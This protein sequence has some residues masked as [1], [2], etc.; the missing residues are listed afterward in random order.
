MKPDKE[1]PDDISRNP[2]E[3]EY[4]NTFSYNPED[5][6]TRADEK[7]D[8]LL[9]NRGSIDPEDL[10]RQGK[11]RAA[12]LASEESAASER[13][14]LEDQVGSLYSGMDKEESGSKKG[15]RQRFNMKSL[16][17]NRLKITLGGGITGLVIAGIIAGFGLLGNFK[18]EHLFQ[19]LD[20]TSYARFN[21]AF[22]RRSDKWFQTYIKMR[23]SEFNGEI[24]N[25][26]EPI[27]FRARSVDTNNP[28]RDWYKTL[29][30]GGFEAELAKKGIVFTS[31]FDSSSGSPVKFTRLALNVEGRNGPVSTSID[32]S[33]L[34]GRDLRNGNLDALIREYDQIIDRKLTQT[35]DTDRDARLAIKKTVDTELN[36]LSWYKR[37]TLRKNIQNMTGVRSW[38]F[39]ETT[40]E[41]LANKRQSV[42]SKF[43]RMA[44]PESTKSGKFI[45]CLMGVGSCN[46]SADPGNPENQATDA[47][48]D[49]PAARDE[50]SRNQF[51]ENGNL[52]VDE[53]GNPLPGGTDGTGAGWVETATDEATDAIENEA[54]DVAG[55]GFK[56]AFI[57]QLLSKFNAATGLVSIADNIRTIHNNIIGGKL[58][59]AI[60]SAKTAQVI[61]VYATYHTISDQ[62]K[63]G[64]LERSGLL[65]TK[66]NP[67]EFNAVME[68]LN[69]F[70]QSEMYNAYFPKKESNAFIGSAFAQSGDSRVG[71]GESGLSRSE[72][73]KETHTP[74]KQDIHYLCAENTVGGKSNAA[75]FT[76][77]YK[78]SVG[79][80]I[81]PFVNAYAGVRDAPGFKQVADLGLGVGNALGNIL[82]PVI[83]GVL[84]GIGLDKGIESALG[85]IMSKVLS[86]AG[87]GPMT[88]FSEPGGYQFNLVAQGS[89]AAAA[90]SA[91]QTGAALSTQLSR[92]YL[93][94]LAAE[95]HQDKLATMSIKNRLFSLSDP[96]SITHRSL[97]ALDSTQSN[98]TFVSTLNPLATISRAFSDT[99]SRLTT[100]TALAQSLDPDTPA[101]L[102]GIEQYDIPDV[103]VNAAPLTTMLS[104][105][106]GTNAE[107][108]LGEDINFTWENVT[109][110]RQ[111][112]EAVYGTERV[113]ALE[114][115]GGDV[116]ALV[117]RIYNCH[118]FD[119]S[120]RASQ[121]KGYEEVTSDDDIL[122]SSVP[123]DAGT[124]STG[125]GSPGQDTSGIPC[126]AGTTPTPNNPQQD[127]GPGRVPT[128]KLNVCDLPTVRGVNS[129][130]AAKALEMINAASAQG[131]TL[132]G[133]AFRSYD[134]QKELRI[135]HGCASD[136]L[137]SSACNPP[138]ARPGTSMHEVG[139]AIDFEGISKKGRNCTFRGNR[140]WEWLTANAAR[141]GFKQLSSECWHWSTTGS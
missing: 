67:D 104:P 110:Q 40:R 78:D 102:A 21:T 82:Q 128:I 32:L 75:K 62:S 132:S 20:R 72:Y 58:T 93:N 55:A 92:T 68:Q 63:S 97:F 9:E 2:G 70:E 98:S 85:W 17:K 123:A 44:I 7:E 118:L 16:A 8:K 138:T 34:R 37:R 130:A 90:S 12:R 141:Y 65:E 129:S 6:S 100:N 94:K 80:V 120:V 126:P 18:L 116:D 13:D 87:G 52:R 50:G 33:E 61:A 60:T 57:R 84:E 41:G 49:G 108:V 136:S 24:N 121:S 131:V 26:G 48:L 22:D 64:E 73:C 107:A 103:C 56:G 76:E 4:E 133:S 30:T 135:A 35:F 25:N 31:S 91:R 42:K 19:N 101:A 88:D 122:G 10:P 112:F 106:S 71:Y 36:S 15:L 11:G 119:Q 86:I 111:F 45:Q 1:L 115:S 3:K 114:K 81:T 127:Y 105:E 23:L 14:E 139:L 59:K 125:V 113:K 38:R 39:F 124:G 51:D 134:R 79:G 95:Q 54:A 46:S 96:D 83:D 29:R 77:S 74:T 140:R 69:G 99:N 27:Y 137:P 5:Y 28:I 53:D 109:D 43:V 66:D 47:P 89:S 117:G